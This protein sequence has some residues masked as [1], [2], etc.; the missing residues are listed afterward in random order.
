LRPFQSSL[1]ASR[2]QLNSL[3]VFQSQKHFLDFYQVLVPVLYNHHLH[4]LVLRHR[5][6]CDQ[7]R[8]NDTCQMAEVIHRSY[9]LLYVDYHLLFAR[10]RPKQ[11]EDVLTKPQHQFLH[12]FDIVPKFLLLEH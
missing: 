4:L 11:D 12:Q 9:L 5:N 2:K 3:V 1:L 7:K 10:N 6:H 8:E